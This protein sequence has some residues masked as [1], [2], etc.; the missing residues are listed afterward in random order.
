MQDISIRTCRFDEQCEALRQEVRDFMAQELPPRKKGASE[1]GAVLSKGSARGVDP[2]FSRKLGKRGWIGMAWSSQYGGHARSPLE[3][4]VLT[5]ELLAAGAPVGAHWIADRQY[6]PLLVRYASENIKND[7]LPRIA[8]GELYICVGM[9]ESDSGSDLASLRTRAERTKGGWLIN[10]RKTWNSAS[11]W[12]HYMVALVRTG[13][14]GETRHGGLTQF[15]IDL[16]APGVSLRPVRILTGEHRWNE[17]TFD[18]VFVPDDHLIG[19]EGKGWA[20]VTTELGF[21]RSGPERY[22]SSLYLLL[23][24]LDAADPANPRHA[25]ALGRLVA[26]MTTIRQ[27]SIGV[28]GMLTRGEN[29]GIAASVVKELGTTFEQQ[30]PEVAHEIFDMDL[31]ALESPLEEMMSFLVQTAP[32]FSIRGGTRE[33]LRGIIARGLGVR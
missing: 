6:G 3:R 32:S 4:Y 16:K 21:E 2:E 12:S 33:I 9:S 7:L 18:D 1:S 31:S 10:G 23:E 17:V 20:Q 25:V 5:E 22:L 28:A 29:P 11:Q 30:I 13:A 26:D 24:M 8:R 27:M 14:A 19:E 15:L